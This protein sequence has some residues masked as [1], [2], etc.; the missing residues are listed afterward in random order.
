MSEPVDFSL[1]G[2]FMTYVLCL[3]LV[4]TFLAK[5]S[6]PREMAF[7]TQLWADLMPCLRVGALYLDLTLFQSAL[8][9]IAH[10]KN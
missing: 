2:Y 10:V 1:S 4:Y 5:Y 3:V 9:L 6:V 7:K 8:S